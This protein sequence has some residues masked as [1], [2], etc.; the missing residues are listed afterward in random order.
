MPA[1]GGV[2]PVHGRFRR[3]GT[4]P[5]NSYF[6]R[7]PKRYDEPGTYADLS[8]PTVNNRSVEW[9]HT[10]GDVVSAI[11]GAGLRIEF[12][13]EHD[14]TLIERWPLLERAEGGSYRLP[15][16]TPALPLMYSLRARSA[17]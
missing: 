5:A 11:V 14:Y 8:A 6:D 12:L 4:E 15:E 13:H 3:G 16:G 2:P 10:M 7:G 9:E 1:S 17:S